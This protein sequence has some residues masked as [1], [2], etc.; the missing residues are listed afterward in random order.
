MSSGLVQGDAARGLDCQPD[1]G[2]A[3][4]FARGINDG[5]YRHPGCIDRALALATEESRG[6]DTTLYHVVGLRRL[7]GVHLQVLGPDDDLGR[8]TDGPVSGH[9]RAEERAAGAMQGEYA[10]APAPRL[11]P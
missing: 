8:V 9:R 3:R 2:A 6:G 7:L 4:N 11:P 1:G 10:A 5:A